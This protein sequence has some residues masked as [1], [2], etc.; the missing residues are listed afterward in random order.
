MKTQKKNKEDL[1]ERLSGSNKNGQTFYKKE[2]HTII[3]TLH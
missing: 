1:K 3:P 2:I